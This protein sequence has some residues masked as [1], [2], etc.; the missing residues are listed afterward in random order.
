MRGG[1]FGGQERMG[2]AERYLRDADIR[3]LR[4][5]LASGAC[6]TSQWALCA[7][8]ERLLGMVEP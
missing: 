7:L 5:A 8:R 1:G 4:L 2:D 3:A 6:S